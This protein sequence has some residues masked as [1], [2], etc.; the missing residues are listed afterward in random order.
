MRELVAV[1]QPSAVAIRPAGLESLLDSFLA[2]HDVKASSKATYRRSLRQFVLWLQETGRADRMASLTR[3]DI[4]AYRDSLDAA[5]KSSYTISTYLAAVRQLYQWLEA[6]K[7]YPDVTKGVKAGKKARGFRKDILSDEQIKKMLATVDRSTLEG[8]RDYALI[9]LLAR[10]GLRTVEAARAQVRDLRQEPGL[11]KGER[12]LWIQG[13]GRD[14]KDDFVLLTRPA[15]Q[16]LKAYL[17]ARRASGSDPLFCSHSDRNY[18]QPLT[19]R[20]ISRI[21]KEAMR[22]VN[23]DDRRLTAHSMRHTAISL[24]VLGGASLQQVQAMA[25]HSDPKTTLVYFHNLDRVRA[26]AERYITI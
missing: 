15:L 18:G 7:Y 13:K 20:S 14:E 16:A 12:V 6:K 2:D 23:L 5:G 26:G 11:Q 25:R 22:R 10:T 1:Q 21:V 17:E 3:E 8:L 24:A 9:S 4:L 19:T